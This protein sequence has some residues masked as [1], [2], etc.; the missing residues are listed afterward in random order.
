MVSYSD[1]L[2]NYGLEII[3]G[4]CLAFMTKNLPQ[5][6]AVLSKNQT[7]NGISTLGTKVNQDGMD[8]LLFTGNLFFF[9]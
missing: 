2:W 4:V 5:I 7:G 1:F 6:P 3:V 9:L 8:R